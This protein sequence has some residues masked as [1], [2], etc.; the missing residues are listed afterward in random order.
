MTAVCIYLQIHQPYRIKRYSVFDIG[1]DHEY[2]NDSSE[3]DTN[4][5]KIL[6]K[7]DEKSYKPTIQTLLSLLEKH[8]EFCFAVSFSGIV[9]DQLRDYAPETIELFKQAVK[10]GRVEVLAETYYHSLSFFYDSAEFEAQVKKHGDLVRDLFDYYPTTFRNT[11]LSNRND[12]ARWAEQ[13]GYKAICA[14]GWEKY[15]GWRSPNYVYAAPKTESIALLLKNYR[16]SDDIAFRFSQESWEGW[17][18]TANKFAQWVHNS[19]G[20]ADVI[21]L[22]MDYETFGEHQWADKGI[23]EFLSHMPEHILQHQDNSFILP[24]QAA[25]QFP[26]RDTVDIPDVLTW[27]DTERDLSAWCDNAM[28]KESLQLIFA[29]GPLVKAQNDPQLLEDWRKLTTSDHFYYM[30]TK[31]AA[32]GDV[33]AYFSPYESPYEAYMNFMNAVQDM[34]WRI[35]QH[36]DKPHVVNPDV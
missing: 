12:L 17:P 6:K 22:F 32:D 11:E 26:R 29:M 19:N 34:R 31:W 27:A 7:V 24:S 3:K 25:Q 5:E 20:S 4:N 9:L 13:S 21:N 15:L 10:T 8:P 14:E 36:S 35:E 30:C 16:L 33:H 1:S 23:F 2:F 18:L 28:Q